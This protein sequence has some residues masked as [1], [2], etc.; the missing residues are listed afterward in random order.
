M[1][2]AVKY[3]EDCKKCWQIEHGTAYHYKKFPTLG[4]EREPCGCQFE[5]FKAFCERRE[6]VP[7]K[8]QLEQAKAYLNGNNKPVVYSNALA[9]GKTA[10]FEQINEFQKEI[11]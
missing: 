11:M 2:F 1:S 9:T 5:K 8:T 4:L 3:C 10:L 6:F 7:N